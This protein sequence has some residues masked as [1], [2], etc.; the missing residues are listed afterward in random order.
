LAWLVGFVGLGGGLGLGVACL[1]DLDPV[2]AQPGDAASERGHDSATSPNCGNGIIED[3]AGEQCDPGPSGA[4]GCTSNCKIDCVSFVDGGQAFVDPSSDHCYFTLGTDDISNALKACKA[5]AAHVV[6][7]V[8]D[9]EYAFVTNTDAATAQAQPFWVG[10]TYLMTDDAGNDQYE[11]Q[12]ANPQEPGWAPYSECTG[13]YAYFMQNPMTATHFPREFLDG[14][15]SYVLASSSWTSWRSAG[16][17]ER[18]LILCEREPPGT[19][20]VECPPD[21]CITL[22]ATLGHKR[23]LYHPNTVDPATTSK[24]A[25]QYCQYLSDGGL[26]GG[27]PPSLVVFDTREE[28]EQLWHEMFSP[29]IV[30][31]PPQQFWVG[32]HELPD[33]GGWFWDDGTPVYVMLD[34]IPPPPWGLGAPEEGGTTRAYAQAAAD[35]PDT[36]LV[37]AAP[38]VGSQVPPFVCQALQ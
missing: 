12:T 25:E 32:A 28:R 34:Q 16:T 36:Q 19:R 20:T 26:D 18:R 29:N 38:G 30:G 5:Q 14:G 15:G 31:G 23:Y 4:E 37:H 13:C 9:N 24:A 2:S 11:S 6:T 33:G 8:S 17:L 35:S 27:Q 1:P 3:D 21:S 22:K 7:F 10:L